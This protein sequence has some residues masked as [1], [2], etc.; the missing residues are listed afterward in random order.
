[1]ASIYGTNGN[2]TLYGFSS[3]D[4]I[5]GFAGNDWLY[6]Y[7]GDD[8]LDGGAN[9]D[10]LYGGTG[11]NDLWG[12]SGYDWFSMST[13]GAGFS[14]DYILDFTFN[15]DRI[16][17]SAWGIS[18]FSQIQAL[19][20]TDP[21]GD[22]RIN[23]YYNGYNHVLTIGN[24]APYSLLSSDFVYSAAGPKN[25]A[26]TNYADVLFGSVYGDALYGYGG[27]DRLLGGIGNDT[28]SGGTGADVI[29]G[30]VGSDTASYITSAAGLTADLLVPSANT[31][32]AA[33]DVY[34]SIENLTGSNYAD[35]LR[36]N[37]FDNVI[38]G[39]QGND[40]LYGRG[41]N[42]RMAGGAGNDY[43]SGN[44]GNDTLWG[45]AGI[46]QLEGGLG[47]DALYGGADNDQFIFRATS[48]TPAGA[49]RDVIFDL[50]DFG[51][52]F[53]N[54]SLMPG[55]SSFIG[56]AAFSAA[57]QVRLMQAGAHV[58]VQINTVGAGGA[59]AEI[60]VANSSI[61]VGAGQV[62]ANDFLL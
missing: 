7:G 37:D 31:G 51:D 28:L 49:G 24:V 45:E 35:S 16:D 10:R 4:S 36:G 23:A 44:A 27:A 6:G 43:L 56:T 41:G 11:Y 46:D 59:E 1:M 18:D 55:V 20:G 12:G 17:V 60:L 48:D 47:A 52:D 40:L 38:S 8:Y 30:G 54:L 5:Y 53:I 57:G 13:R 42:D 3:H 25:E 62:W 39:L 61:G 29:N 15:V 58:L 22:A 21:G 9:D 32:E 34:Q 19:L 2:N 50:D 33:G 14:D 26:G